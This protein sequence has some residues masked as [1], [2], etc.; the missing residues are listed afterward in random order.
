MS[1]EEYDCLLVSSKTLQADPQAA[2]LPAVETAPGR[3]PLP[4]LKSVSE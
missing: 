3:D 1:F 2:Q 4:E